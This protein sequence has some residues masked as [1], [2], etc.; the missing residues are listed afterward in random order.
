M[1]HN[2]LRRLTSLVLFTILTMHFALA[3]NLVKISGKVVDELNE[4]IIGVSVFEK[5]NLKRYHHR[6]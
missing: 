3:Q 6:S 2:S 4:P 5:R 1:K